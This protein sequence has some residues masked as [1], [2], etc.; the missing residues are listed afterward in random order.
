MNPDVEAV[1]AELDGH[2]M[3][4][5]VLCRSLS[6]EELGRPVP[7]STWLVRDFIAHLATIDG[8]VDEMFRTVHKGGDAGIRAGDGERF[9]V[10]RWNEARVQER[11]QL[12]VDEML[13]EA[14]T[15]RTQLRGTLASLTE[16]D[17]T[18]TIKFQG[19]ARRPPA[20]IELRTYLRGWCKHDVMHAADMM[21]ALPDRMTP[22]RDHWFDDPVVKAYLNAMNGAQE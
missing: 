18:K 5:T 20:D 21:R 8:P 13:M 15:V 22:R 11:R 4:F 3:Q 6:E 16:E 7:G 17:I 14:A 1:L 10:D 12:S 9:D 19:D 2:R